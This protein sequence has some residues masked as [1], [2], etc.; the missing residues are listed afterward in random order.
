MAR[1]LASS[2]ALPLDSAALA[3]ELDARDPLRAF[4]EEFHL[5]TGGDGAPLLYFCG[6]SLGLQPKATDGAVAAELRKWACR[7]VHG[8]F[9]GALPWATCEEAL[10][11]LLA[12]VVGAARPAVEVAAMNSLTVNLHLLM[13]AFYRPAAGRAAILIEGSAFPSDRY[14]VA[15]QI[16][17]HGYDPSEW[18]IEVM[19]RSD[20]H[21]FHTED[22]LAAIEKHR[23]RLALV[24]LGGVNYL[25]G[26]VLDM[27]R[28]AEHM[29]ESNARAEAAGEP[30]VPLGLDL[31]HAVGNVPLALHE[32]GV[33]FAAWCSYKYLNGGAGGLAGLFVHEKHARDREKYPRLAGWWGVPFSRRFAMAHAFECADGAAGFGVSNVNPLMVACVHAS[34]K[35]L[36]RAGGVAATRR[37]SV[38]LTGYLEALLQERGLTA[39]RDGSPPLVQQVTPAD[40]AQRGCQI[41]LR[42]LP[43]PHRAANPPTM[44]DLEQ[45]LAAHGVVTDA[46]EPDI[47]R[48]SPVPLYNSFAEV[49]QCVGVLQKCLHELM[50]E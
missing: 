27:P 7:G 20:D 10:P 4:R 31:A 37:K 23:G 38:L 46:R 2:L 1:A 24:L 48:I 40:E 33:D 35:T 45:L 9:E 15:S 11:A 41:S 3:A 49:Y 28:I 8:H 43:P 14:A 44:R 25:N 30:A 50:K 21:L 47:V 6:N 42:V 12:D 17:H 39:A 22:I 29:R 16:E 34:L 13:A 36:E 5:P 32:W 19:P 26:Q 18:L